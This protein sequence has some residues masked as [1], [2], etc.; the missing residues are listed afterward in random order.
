MTPDG[1]ST[2]GQ[3][4]II[5]DGHLDNETIEG[6]KMYK[7]GDWYYIFSPAGGVP[8]GWQEVLRSKNPWGP[9]ETRNVLEQG[10]SRYTIP[11]P[12]AAIQA[13]PL[14]TQ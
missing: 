14:L 4:R 2:I 1:K 13:N 10:D 3:D 6:A 11:I 5:Y 8:T 7:R 12:T 9:Y